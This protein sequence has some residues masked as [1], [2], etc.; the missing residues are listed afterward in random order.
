MK[1][2]FLYF[3][4]RGYNENQVSWSL[5]INKEKNITAGLNSLHPIQLPTPKQKLSLIHNGM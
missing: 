1:S 2:L 3:I 5:L 4:Y